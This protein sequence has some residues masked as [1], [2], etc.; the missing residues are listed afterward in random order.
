ML[1]DIKKALGLNNDEFDLIIKNYIDAA[2]LDLE[3]SGILKEK[4][5]DTDKLIYSTIFCYVQSKF[6]IDN[7]EMFLNSYNLQKDSLRHNT[8][9]IS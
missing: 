2:K 6:D 4:I 5:V 8:S 7:S 1:E 9:Y 3:A